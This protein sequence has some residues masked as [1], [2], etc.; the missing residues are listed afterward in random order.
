MPCSSS[1][2]ARDHADGLRDVFERLIAF[3]DA[4]RTRGE[5]V[6]AFCGGCAFLQGGHGDRRHGSSVRALRLALHNDRPSSTSGVQAASREQAIQSFPHGEATLHCGRA[7]AFDQC[8]L[9]HQFQV[10]LACEN[11]QSLRQRLGSDLDFN[12]P[13]QRGLH[14]D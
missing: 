13:G 12:R 8:R 1:L 4:Y 7:S 3:V 14:T 9:H 6:R 11:H 2:L 5:R 10:R